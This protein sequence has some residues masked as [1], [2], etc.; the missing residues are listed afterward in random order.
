MS[1]P[2]TALVL[3]AGELPGNGDLHPPR[4]VTWGGTSGALLDLLYREIGCDCVDSSPDLWTPDGA[5]RMWGDDEGLLR[6]PVAHNDR[7]L[8]ICRALG[9][10]TPD[11][12]GT[13]VFTGGTDAEGDTLTVPD[14]FVERIRE[15]CAGV[16]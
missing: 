14:G 11:V 6:R 8:A 15:S 10:D 7:A 9:Y 12:G 5:V 4:T 1:A 13:V 2:Y 16:P 3:P